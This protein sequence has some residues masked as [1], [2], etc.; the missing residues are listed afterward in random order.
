MEQCAVSLVHSILQF[1]SQQQ[2]NGATYNQ[3][4]HTKH[5][6]PIYARNASPNCR[7][8]DKRRIYKLE[9]S[10]EAKINK[11]KLYR[12]SSQAASQPASAPA[13]AAPE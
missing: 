7:G 13:E 3:S 5:K 8:P 2:H 9:K 4:I 6:V 10:T 1:A 11:Q 12:Q